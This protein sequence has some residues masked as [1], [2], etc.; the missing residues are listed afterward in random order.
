[1]WGQ[2]E[3]ILSLSGIEPCSSDPQPVT[4]PATYYIAF[5]IHPM[6]AACPVH[7]TLLEFAGARE[8]GCRYKNYNRS[9]NAVSGPIFILHIIQQN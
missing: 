7:L 6:R 2:T 8:K 5:L 9:M 4:I 1:M 3:K